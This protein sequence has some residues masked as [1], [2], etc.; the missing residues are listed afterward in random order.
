VYRKFPHAIAR[1]RGLCAQA[2]LS[3]EP[4]KG[5]RPHV[6]PCTTRTEIIMP[7]A[8]RFVAAL[9]L[10][11]AML[12]HSP[13]SFAQ[14]TIRQVYAPPVFIDCYY[15][16]TGICNSAGA[17]GGPY[18]SYGAPLGVR[19][20]YA[21]IGP[22]PYDSYAAVNGFTQPPNGPW[23]TRGLTGGDWTAIHGAAP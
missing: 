22:V 19:G 8:T 2:I 14:R 17:Y 5:S 6:V 23:F 7:N 4:P 9:S 18:A 20:A 12:V 3:P 16:T 13:A 10:A 21:A 1:D 11:G 15:N